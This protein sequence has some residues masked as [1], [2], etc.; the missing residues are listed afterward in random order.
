MKARLNLFEDVMVSAPSPEQQ[1]VFRNAAQ[2]MAD[3]SMTVLRADG[4]LSFDIKG[5]EKVLTVT[6]GKL[7]PHMGHTDLDIFDQ[8]LRDRGLQVE[9]LLNP[10][11]EELRNKAE[12]FDLIFI[13]IDNIPFAQ[14]G[15]VIV[16]DTFRTWGWRSLYR[17]HPKVAYT[18]FG[19]PYVVHELPAVPRLLAAYGNSDCSQRAAVKVWLGEIE[20]AGILPVHLPRVEIKPL[21]V[22]P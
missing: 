2:T 20:P 13:N 3:K 11:S 18:A 10:N 7:A 12:V 8:E 17:M 22:R 5:D 1:I 9:H 15:T 19:S 14:L 16:T 6:I 21:P 4:Q